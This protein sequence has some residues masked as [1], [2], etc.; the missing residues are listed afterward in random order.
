MTWCP[1]RLRALSRPTIV[2]RP[3]SA[4][5]RAL[6]GLVAIGTLVAGCAAPTAYPLDS[7]PGATLAIPAWVGTPLTTAVAS[8]FV[9][10][11]DHVRLIG[12]DPIGSL[13]GATVALFLSRPER[14]EDCTWVTG[15]LLEPL[16]G[17]DVTSASEP[18]G[19][20][21]L[22]GAIV[23]RITPLRAGRFE[24]TDLRIRY[25][26]ND[27]PERQRDTIGT[28]WYVCAATPAP[29]TCPPPTGQP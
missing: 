9:H 27:G 3:R 7:G 4:L 23:A 1:S 11:G 21:D 26:L 29:D 15:D 22:A 17:A 13:H 14:R 20:I 16:A 28:R 2:G 5:L 10:P 12:A 18:P 6:C 24:L 19:A 25:R 8:I